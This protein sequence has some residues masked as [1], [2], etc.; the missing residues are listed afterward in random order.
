MKKQ[1]LT[2]EILMEKYSDYLL[3]NGKQP[4]NVYTFA[5]ENNFSEA[6]FYEYFAGFEA[7]EQAYLVYFFD[8]SVSLAKQIEG[9]GEMQ[10]KEQLLNLY[11]I[12]FE[13]L[14][15]NRSLVLTLLK[16][17]LRDRFHILKQLKSNHH[18]LVKELDFEQGKLFENAPERLKNFTEKSREEVLWLHFLSV[19][20]F[21]KK[22][23]S[24]SFEKTDLYI[25]KSIDTGFDIVQNPLIDKFIDLGKFLWKEKFQMS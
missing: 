19:L 9:F 20:D 13:N 8:K 10:A 6:K 24:P 23:T 5:K 25:E 4:V 2:K 21:W 12:F 16:N 1:Q 22:D 11:F 14:N 3:S 15:L 18:N 7:L 17:D